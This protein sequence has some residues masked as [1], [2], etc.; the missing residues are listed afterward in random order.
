MRQRMLATSVSLIIAS[1]AGCSSDIADDAGA[2]NPASSTPTIATRAPH[3]TPPQT[4]KAAVPSPATQL[5]WNGPSKAEPALPRL[6]PLPEPRPRSNRPAPDGVVYG[7]SARVRIRDGWNGDVRWDVMDH[8]VQCQ[9]YDHALYWSAG[10]HLLDDRPTAGDGGLAI[11]VVEDHTNPFDPA[12][13]TGRRLVLTFKDER[14][15]THKAIASHPDANYSDKASL[16]TKTS[17]DKRQ[18]TASAVMVA[19]PEVD[20]NDQRIAW[21]TVTATISCDG[22]PPMPNA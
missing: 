18:I 14:G 8:R 10:T 17:P 4:T 15:N 12:R 13:V 7:G 19:H 1:T 20:F 16:M 22:R 2:K 6:P 11:Q 5:R 21:V 9:W 3:R